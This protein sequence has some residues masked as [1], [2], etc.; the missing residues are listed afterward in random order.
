MDL[1]NKLPQFKELDVEFSKNCR[2]VYDIL[3]SNFNKRIRLIEACS[4]DLAEWLTIE[5]KNNKKWKITKD[6]II[7]SIFPKVK[8]RGF[9][10]FSLNNEYEDLGFFRSIDLKKKHN[11]NSGIKIEVAFGLDKINWYIGQFNGYEDNEQYLDL[12]F[13]KEALNNV[14]IPDNRKYKSR[15]VFP[16]T[17]GIDS[18]NND[19][20]IDVSINFKDLDR[21]LVIKVQEIIKF[22][23]LNPMILRLTKNS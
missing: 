10:K 11:S 7:D 18:E 22:K 20:L 17:P 14:N 21:E 16:N 2:K 6:A 1:Q 9:T 4:D 12:N 5:L 3:M 15:I 23:I 19:K 8:D 13:Y